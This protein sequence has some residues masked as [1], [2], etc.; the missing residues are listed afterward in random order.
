[1]LV[2]AGPG[3]QGAWGA[4]AVVHRLEPLSDADAG[5]AL[6]DLAPEAGSQ[7]EADALGRLLGGLPLALRLAGLTIAAGHGRLATF[8][9]YSGAL[10]R[11]PV[12][13]RLLDVASDVALDRGRRAVVMR[14]T[15]LSLDVLAEH[16]L[17][18]SRALL[19]LLSCYAPGQ[20]IPV[21]LLRQA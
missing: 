9:A 15:E 3:E 7:S 17:P 2:T 13:T 11:V 12:P 8:E 16:G 5:D 14:S 10:D 21:E 18:E 4:R 6:R 1:V 20:P 19:R